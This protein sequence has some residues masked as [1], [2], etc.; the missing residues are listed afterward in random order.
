MVYF[1]SIPTDQDQRESAGPWDGNK[2]PRQQ[3]KRGESNKHTGGRMVAMYVRV[4][5]RTLH[6][7]GHFVV[8]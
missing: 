1:L 6:G 3:R 7:N 2:V 8:G 5:Y 4:R